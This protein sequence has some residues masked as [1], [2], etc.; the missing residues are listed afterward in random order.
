[1]RKGYLMLLFACLF[2]VPAFG[3]CKHENYIGDNDVTGWMYSYYS[4]WTPGSAPSG[5]L[6]N[7]NFYIGRVRP[8]KRFTNE[9]TQVIQDGEI[10]RRKNRGLLW[11][12]PINESTWTSL[13]R[14]A[15]DSEAFSMWS[16][17]T[18]YGNWTQGF[19]RQP[20]AFADVC[21]KNGVQTACV[22]AAPWAV[23]LSS[24]D[25]GHG[26]NYQA[27]I[28][29]GYEKLLKLF[30]YYGI[31]G[32]GFN[33]EQ[34]WGMRN[35]MKT[36][37]ANCQSHKTDNNGYNGL[38][39]RLHFDFYQ[40]NSS[41][42]T[43]Q[44]SGYNWDDFFPNAN[45]FFLNYNWTNSILATSASA[46]TQLGGSSYDVYA[47]MDMQGGNAGFHWDYIKSNNV[48]VGIWGAHNKN[49][50]YEGAVADG[51]TAKAI[52]NCYLRRCEQFFTGGTK[53]PVNDIDVS[54]GS[55]SPSSS[56][57]GVA[58]LVAAKSTLSWTA[59]DYF[60]FIT[61]LNLGNGKFFN[62][63]G[64]TTYND[65]WYNI[66]MQDFMPTWRWWITTSYMGRST[67]YVPSDTHAS[68]TY[69]DAW[70]GG[71]CLKLTFDNSVSGWRYIQLFK[72]QFPIADA[73]YT[74][75]VRYKALS[76]S[77]NMQYTMSKEGA[78]S[79]IITQSMGTM[80]AGTGEWQVIEKAVPTNIVGSTMAQLGMRFNNIVDGTEIL[81]GEIAL[82]KNGVTYAP[83]CPTLAKTDI[84]KVT[85][86]GIDFKTTWNSHLDG[87]S[88]ATEPAV[89][90]CDGIGSVI[91]PG[92]DTGSSTGVTRASTMSCTLSGTSNH[93]ERYLTSFSVSGTQGAS[94]AS[95][96]IQSGTR[97]NLYYDLR[98]T[99]SLE[100]KRGETISI[101][102]TWNGSWMMGYVYVDWNNDGDFAD[103][104]EYMAS[105]Y[106]INGTSYSTSIWA[107]PKDFTI[108]ADAALG[109]YTI[110]YTVDWN[111][112][113][114]NDTND[115]GASYPCGRTSS[116]APDNYTADN[117]GC[118][119]DFELKVTNDASG[120]DA[121]GSEGT[122]TTYTP[123]GRNAWEPV[124][125]DEVDTWYFEIW[126]Q[127]C[128]GE[129]Q[130]ITCTTSWAAY[131]VEAPFDLDGAAGYRVGV[132]A[133]APDGVTKSDIQ[134]SSYLDASHI[135][136]LEGYS[137]DKPV[138]KPNE[139]FTVSFDDKNHSEAVSWKIY[140][141]KDNTLMAT[142]T[143]GTSF[144]TTLSEKGL[145]DLEVT[146]T[147]QN[148][149]T[150]TE[151][152]RAMI[153]V[154]GEEVG[155]VPEIY[156]LNVDNNTKSI[157]SNPTVTFDFD[158]TG[159]PSEGS[160]SQA[161][162]LQE[163]AFCFQAAS[164]KTD[165]M[166]FGTSPFTIA[167]WFKIENFITDEVGLFAISSPSDTWPANNWGYIWSSLK[168]SSL[169][170][171][172]R[173]ESVNGQVGFDLQDFN[174]TPGY[175]YHIAIASDYK[176]SQGRN[177][178]IFVNGASI[179]S[180]GYISNTNNGTKESFTSTNWT[181]DLYSWKTDN[182]FGIGAQL[183]G[184]SAID[185]YIDEVQIW[186]TAKTS[187]EILDLMEHQ[188]TIAND[189]MFYWDFESA[190]VN[191]KFTSTGQG[192]T[193][194]GFVTKASL[195][196]TS[197]GVNNPD[198]A[199]DEN[200]VTPTL[201]A[202]SPF[203]AG[204]YPVNTTASWK[205]TGTPVSKGTPTAGVDGADQSGT[206]SVGYD[207]EGEYVATLT[208]END[209]GQ[210]SRDI[211]VYVVDGTVDLEGN[212][213]ENLSV[214]PNPF[215]DA[216]ILTFAKAGNYTIE[217]MG[218]DGRLLK[219][220][221]VNASACQMSRIAVEGEAGTYLVRI[222][223]Q[224]KVVQTLKLIKK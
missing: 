100:V 98:N 189:L 116:T 7:E 73:N 58:K 155:A 146:Y 203:L 183:N 79:T 89:T 53:N 33:S 106:N 67:S 223:Q 18:I 88:T 147:N 112:Q 156:T 165:G 2:A 99:K 217:V 50:L 185:G 111:S 171:C 44:Q 39:D 197:D 125:N 31:D 149:A 164:L 107:K 76:G 10:T 182:N 85:S 139:T 144:S 16:Y 121:N 176:S 114:G 188:E 120:S 66:G 97:K 193:A 61:Y 35:G 129:P 190:A 48:S 206:M 173:R 108:P 64:V 194:Q 93:S 170:F 51:S 135:T 133:V 128:G 29:G 204:S 74:L 157:T 142:F 83:V 87:S 161:L 153:Q 124:Y 109:T 186:N 8:L 163:Q 200:L 222:K 55:C 77:A 211:T 136:I 52:Q 104:G 36:L 201:A 5:G 138:I 174:F 41:L 17:V 150:V 179:A 141:S 60:P 27:L 72:T 62:N 80:K 178:N 187:N 127:Q 132:R 22:S 34:T 210:D 131:A 180:D 151:K 224:D 158:Y 9:A 101:S 134:W 59:N 177:I 57:H 75:R 70:F 102:P 69:E 199:S 92:G 137:V 191:K 21:H 148:G 216:V 4:S 115:Q 25:G 37:I 198:I 32:L 213:V 113:S 56:F 202:G 19:L 38:S 221:T 181:T 196:G 78:E 130:L 119:V 81:I 1:M 205:F 42:T 84:L 208:L 94:L 214:Y 105:P 90:S 91:I 11:W 212:V 15:F 140:R 28:D 168:P 30:C 209:H 166:N 20:G 110:R 86:N 118:M 43:S 54:A 13:P 192:N 65:E 46:A 123:S 45:G 143:G 24:T 172:F 159:R 160:T 218:L 49:M 215:T 3:F 6:E 71:S 195:A 12:C 95:G 122:A 169:S 96:T 219:S 220:G 207:T 184:R 145:Y 68:F 117:G 40:F 47:G 162:R 23:S 63:E 175:W 154:S 103:S 26:Q 152:K 126:G 167:F 14:Y 82:V